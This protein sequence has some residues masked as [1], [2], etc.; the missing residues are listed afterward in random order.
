MSKSKYKSKYNI[1]KLRK[2]W[3]NQSEEEHSESKFDY[4][5][6]QINHACSGLFW[7]KSDGSVFLYR[8]RPTDSV[9]VVCKK[10]LGSIFPC[11]DR[12][13]EVNKKL[14]ISC[15]GI[16]FHRILSI[17]IATMQ[18]TRVTDCNCPKKYQKKNIVWK[19]TTGC[20][21]VDDTTLIFSTRSEIF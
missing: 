20:Y 4:Q 5:E 12:A 13:S 6:V 1:C 15:S 3:L 10:E 17:S 9:S 7:E 21:G 2:K 16:D 14:L 11:T 8:P 18:P 19:I